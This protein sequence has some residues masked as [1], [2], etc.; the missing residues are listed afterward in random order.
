MIDDLLAPSDHF[1]E[2][3]EYAG[4]VDDDGWPAS[5]EELTDFAVHF[6]CLNICINPLPGQSQALST[7]IPVYR[8]FA[9]GRGIFSHLLNRVYTEPDVQ[10]S[11]PEG[12]QHHARCPPNNILATPSALPI[13]EVF[14]SLS[15][16]PVSASEPTLVSPASVN[17]PFLAD[18][19]RALSMEDDSGYI[20]ASASDH[21]L[22]GYSNI[23][24]PSSS[25]IILSR[26]VFFR[27]S[28]AT[29][30]M[31]NAPR[32]HGP[33]TET[34]KPLDPGSISDI[35]LVSDTLAVGQ[36][37]AQDLC[38][39]SDDQSHAAYRNFCT[40]NSSK[41]LKKRAVLRKRQEAYRRTNQIREILPYKRG[42]LKAYSKVV[43]SKAALCGVTKMMRPSKP[44]FPT[45]YIRHIRKRNGAPIADLDNNDGSEFGFTNIQQR[46]ETTGQKVAVSLAFQVGKARGPFPHYRNHPVYDLDKHEQSPAQLLTCRRDQERPQVPV[47]LGTH[48]RRRRHPLRVHATISIHSRRP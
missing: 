47:Q 22:G 25:S 28:E 32:H 1:M 27:N 45:Y 8:D 26:D 41:L 7:N 29:G 38:G 46:R 14:L 2:D 35:A 11:R 16:S 36:N 40:N 20:S 19:D 21:D 42:S 13:E 31:P 24:T 4:D 23:L 30:D 3:I 44:K 10:H 37:A 43:R 18:G 33:M 5:L 12:E 6:D 39:L 15:A 9:L 48:R 34:A 17:S